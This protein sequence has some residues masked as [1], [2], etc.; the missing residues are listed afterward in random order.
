MTARGRRR[1]FVYRSGTICDALVRLYRLRLTNW[2]G[3]HKVVVSEPGQAA[4]CNRSPS[5]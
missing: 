5:Y 1:G 2:I 4:V 3:P